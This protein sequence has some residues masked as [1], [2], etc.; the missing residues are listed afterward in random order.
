MTLTNTLA[1]NP[2]DSENIPLSIP[3]FKGTESCLDAALM[4]ADAGWYVL[5][6]RRGDYKNPGSVVGAGWPEKSSRDA[7]LIVGWFYGTDYGI[8]LHTGKSG[9]VVVDL[10]HPGAWPEEYRKFLL[11]NSAP[12]QSSDPDDAE[13]GHYIFA[14]E[15]HQFG[16]SVAGFP[17]KGWG[18]VRGGNSVIIAY[19]ST[20]A[21]PGKRYEWQTDG[22]AAVMPSVLEDWLSAPGGFAGGPVDGSITELEDIISTW[23]EPW[24]AAD[25]ATIAELDAYADWTSLNNG[26]SKA[27]RVMGHVLN[28]A[29]D[30][31]SGCGTLVAHCLNEVEH[32][33]AAHRQFLKC[34]R[35][36]W[37]DVRKIR[38]EQ[39]KQW[40]SMPQAERVTSSTNDNNSSTG[41]PQSNAEPTSRL[42]DTWADG[43]DPEPP[44][45]LD[46]GNGPIVR[47]ATLGTIYAEEKQGK[48]W[49]AMAWAVLEAVKGRR[50]LYVD[51][52]NGERRFR[53]RIKAAAHVGS[54]YAPDSQA[55]ALM[56]RFEDRIK[57]MPDPEGWITDDE[58]SG[59]DLI[60]IDAAI[61]FVDNHTD[62]ARNIDSMNSAQAVNKAYRRLQRV[63]RSTNACVVLI[64][65]S[66][67]DGKT[68]GNRRKRGVADWQAK[69][70]KHAAEGYTTIEW[71]FDRDDE[72]DT[73]PVVYLVFDG[74]HLQPYPPRPV[75]APTLDDWARANAAT[76]EQTARYRQIVM[77]VG[78][79][80]GQTRAEYRRRGGYQARDIDALVALG[81]LTLDGENHVQRHPTCPAE[82]R[83]WWEF[84][85]E[86]K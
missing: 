17:F 56:A 45:L 58:L 38:L 80:P 51:Y 85:R 72:N 10:D 31:Y 37:T 82:W 49:G 42:L 83:W 30:G 68:S 67:A 13:H 69:A 54:I 57:Y 3:D 25:A 40:A 64:D 46:T 33:D 22:P 75:V 11:N 44:T 78:R 76:T 43:P 29:A 35:N 77:E 27:P 47:P 55:A 26:E 1:H 81:I 21:K 36:L 4:Y 70:E 23:V 18:E 7:S 66:N 34:A 65:H 28:K 62:T 59:Y 16:S 39:T 60:I 32:N 61:D 73:L 2:S 53:K 48:T 9:A 20:H 52:E 15:D 50:V 41:E 19:P 63:A 74:Y 79:D 12:F 84:S 71:E 86:E 24:E 14:D 8:A 6:V 5:P